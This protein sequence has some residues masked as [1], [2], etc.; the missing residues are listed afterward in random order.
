MKRVGVTLGIKTI[1]EP[2]LKAVREAGLE[3]VEITPEN[4]P[5]SVAGLDGLLLCGGTDV[6]PETY[7]QHAHRETQKPDCARDEMERRLLKG[8]LEADLPV[9]AICRGLQLL[10]VAQGGTLIQ[11]LDPATGHRV[12]PEDKAEPAHRA[13]AIPGTRLAAILGEDPLPVNSRHHQAVDRLGE[14]LVV[15]ARAADGVV[16]AI[17]K[18]DQ[19]FAVA[20]QW[21]PEDGIERDARLF[22]S[23][24]EA[25]RGE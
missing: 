12:V 2:Y 5:E 15:S 18:P 11:H 25:V 19:R 23:F 8:A 21:H 9:L 3:P 13:A 14:G 4:A 6:N 1:R 7:G 20:V 10:N 16:E 24:A 17:E 22:A